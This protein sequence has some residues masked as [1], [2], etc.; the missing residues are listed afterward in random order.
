MWYSFKIK[1]YPQLKDLDPLESVAGQVFAIN[2]HIEKSFS[3]LMKHFM[4]FLEDKGRGGNEKAITQSKEEPP[5]KPSK[6]DIE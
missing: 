5:K 4:Q 6:K 3:L 2:S 1:E